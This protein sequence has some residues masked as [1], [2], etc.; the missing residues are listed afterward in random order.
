MGN[1]RTRF[2]IG[3]CLSLLGNCDC[4]KTD[5]K[6]TS[7]DTFYR[8]AL[9][10]LLRFCRGFLENPH[11]RIKSFPSRV[12]CC[13]LPTTYKSQRR[14]LLQVRLPLLFL[15]KITLPLNRT[16]L[17]TSKSIEVHLSLLADYHKTNKKVPSV[18]TCTP[19]TGAAFR[20]F[21]DRDSARA[22]RF[23]WE[24][25]TSGSERRHPTALTCPKH[26][27]VN[28]HHTTNSAGCW[29]WTSIPSTSGWA[30]SRSMCSCRRC[31][32]WVISRTC[33]GNSGCRRCSSSTSSCQ[34]TR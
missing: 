1:Q 24:S 27:A 16:Q 14:H 13:G 31:R 26:V 2:L 23:E 8:F 5:E 12:T 20:C 29:T 34:S 10:Y 30:T 25:A 6:V 32:H 9:F 4:L 15:S 3:I 22:W 33:R 19:S 21:S 18:G 11:R 7:A 28:P 17:G